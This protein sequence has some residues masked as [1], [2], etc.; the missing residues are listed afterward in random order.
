MLWKQPHHTTLM[1]KRVKVIAN[2]EKENIWE[3]IVEEKMIT[4]VTME[5]VAA[6][7]QEDGTG[8]KIWISAAGASLFSTAVSLGNAF[9]WSCKVSTQLKSFSTF[10]SER[11]RQQHQRLKVLQLLKL[12]QHQKLMLSS[13]SL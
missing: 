9:A 7:S 6:Q 3:Q 8:M 10:I 5:D 4:E 13:I 2:Q 11:V 1:K 12:L